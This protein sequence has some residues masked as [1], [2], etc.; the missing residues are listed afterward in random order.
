[1][2]GNVGVTTVDFI[3]LDRVKPSGTITATGLVSNMLV[4]NSVNQTWANRLLSEINYK[5][6]GKDNLAASITSDDVTAGVS[7]TWYLTSSEVFTEKELA[8]R[9]DWKSYKDGS[10]PLMANQNVIVYEKII[11]KAGNTSYYSSDNMAGRQYK[12][13]DG[14]HNYTDSPVLGEGRL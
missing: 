14:Y 4:P 11:D 8:A 5:L 10:L 9:T 3:T 13:V 1:M 2:A 6:F 7:S 12:P